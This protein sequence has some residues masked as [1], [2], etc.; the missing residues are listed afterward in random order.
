MSHKS[1]QL[2]HWVFLLVRWTR[3]STSHLSQKES[4]LH[5]AMHV[6]TAPRA[7]HT[8]LQLPRRLRKTWGSLSGS[9]LHRAAV[10]TRIWKGCSCYITSIFTRSCLDCVYTAF[11]CVKK[12]LFIA[13]LGWSHLMVSFWAHFAS[14]S[15]R[16]K[17][18]NMD[19]LIEDQ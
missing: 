12:L 5:A 11:C 8:V 3:A 4:A 1:N 17:N 16:T 13:D 7:S 14:N 9:T 15:I 6:P 18:N 19:N 2:H 10:W